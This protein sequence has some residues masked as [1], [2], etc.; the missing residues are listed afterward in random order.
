[1]NDGVIIN[2]IDNF[3]QGR[4]PNIILGPLLDKI[5]ESSSCKYGLVGETKYTKHQQP[6][7]RFHYVVGFPKDSI[8]MKN[9][10]RDGYVDF[11]QPGTL[12]SEVYTTKQIVIC[13]D[14]MA[15]RNGRPIG[16]AHPDMDNFCI[17]PLIINDTIIGV[18]GVSGYESKMTMDW[19]DTFKSDV[20]V[21]KAVLTL[22]IQRNAIETKEITFLSHLFNEMKTPLNG[23]ISMSDMLRDSDL[24]KEQ[25]ELLDL[26]SHCNIQLLEIINDI[27]DYTKIS[28]G[29][30]QINHNT[31]SLKNLVKSIIQALSSKQNT[32]KIT[33]KY[34]TRIDM[35]NSDEVRIT[36][37]LLNLLNNSIEH[38][39]KGHISL[40][41]ETVAVEMGTAILKFVISDTGKGIDSDLLPYAFD[42]TSK[43]STS[44][45]GLGLPITKK[46]VELFDG[47]ISIKSTVGVGTTVTFTLKFSEKHHTDTKIMGYFKGQHILLVAND[48]V[49]KRE[50]FDVSIKWGLKPVI[51][52]IR[53]ATMYLSGKIFT[54]VGVIV[55]DSMDLNI[56]TLK[57]Y[58]SP[59]AIRACN[60]KLVIDDTFDYIYPITYS[61]DRCVHDF[62]ENIYTLNNSIIN[63]ND[64]NDIK[65]LV[66]TD[67]V[68]TQKEIA[69]ELN[70]MGYFNITIANDGLDLYMKLQDSYNIAFIDL[71][72][73]VM[74]CFMVL[75]KFKQLDQGSNVIILGIAPSMSEN[76]RDNCY[77]V[78]MSGYITKPIKPYE[79]K[80]VI[81][82]MI[83]KKISDL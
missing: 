18:V 51:C 40:I 67:S 19:V 63:D 28:K 10:Y 13:N 39:V 25:L 46:L 68:V 64:N 50:A 78:G 33:Y 11:M 62:L 79:I 6:Y 58:T 73:P 57:A 59:K 37:I 31:F 15:H 12:H 55:F 3:M 16:H 21:I 77:R 82:A 66:A 69:S 32:V 53:E 1:M 49:V 76:I 45:I 42:R 74:D 52:N 7:T 20:Q 17:I 60:N 72:I 30:L 4:A 38:T 2:A 81:N 23:I 48:P 47:N 65:I 80:S 83:R 61:V 29:E 34:N 43:L 36:Q 24:N 44:K 26:I 75:E 56:E 70:K 54:F 71:E 8:Y 9:I 14:V 35:I 41:I 5:V 27:G 22:I